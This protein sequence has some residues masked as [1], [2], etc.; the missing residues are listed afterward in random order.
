M[1]HEEQRREW[2]RIWDNNGLATNYER[3]IALLANYTGEDQDF[4][5]KVRLF[6]TTNRHHTDAITTVLRAEHQ[7][8]REKRESNLVAAIK[9]ATTNRD[10]NGTLARML[11]FIDQKISSQFTPPGHDE[12]GAGNI[13]GLTRT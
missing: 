12:T 4:W 1:T 11:T 3:I 13:F 2:T 5:G 6:F 9:N 8:N 10:P 7:S